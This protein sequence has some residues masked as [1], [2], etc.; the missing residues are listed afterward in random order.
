VEGTEQL[1]VYEALRSK[2]DPARVFISSR[3]GIGTLRRTANGWRF[4]GMIPGSPPHA[5]TLVERDGVLWIGT[6]F[7]GVLRF[8]GTRFQ[9]IGGKIESHVSEIGGR[10]MVR[11]TEGVFAVDPQDRLVRDEPL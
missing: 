5:R 7:D 8:D 11:T 9:P 3:K 2:S 6:T 4:E 1:V 10:I